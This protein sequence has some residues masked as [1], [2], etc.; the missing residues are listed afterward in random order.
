MSNAQTLGVD[1]VAALATLDAQ[2]AADNPTSVVVINTDMDNPTSGPQ[3]FKFFVG[4]SFIEVA[5]CR[6]SNAETVLAVRNQS[7]DKP[8]AREATP[9]DVASWDA[10]PGDLY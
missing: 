2:E 7:T 10:R 5:V 6:A 4:G 9:A 3:W 1:A 8:E